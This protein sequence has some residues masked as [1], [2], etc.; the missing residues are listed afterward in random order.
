MKSLFVYDITHDSVVDGLGVR[1]VVWF[2]G[3]PNNCPGCH[4]KSIQDLYTGNL[5]DVDILAEELNKESKITFSGG[6]PLFQLEAFDD[7][8]GLLKDS[9]D[10]WVYTGY[11]Y[12]DTLEKISRMKNFYSR[13]SYI[14]V[15]PYIN[16]LK[17][18]DCKFRGSSNQKIYKVV[19]N[20]LQ[21][22]SDEIDRR[23]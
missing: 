9:I 12:K 3:C 19:G 23:D 15:G 11:N 18:M 8:L 13:V 22:I 4:N 7:L 17:S 5:Y 2:S 21:D 16:S 6:D 14:K 1:T 10:V 20:E